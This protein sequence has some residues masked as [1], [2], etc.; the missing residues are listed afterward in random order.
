MSINGLT[1]EVREKF[2]RIRPDTLGQASRIPG[3]TPAAI[4]VLSIA[5]KAQIWKIDREKTNDSPSY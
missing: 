2:S 5:L 4:A 3:V 1:S